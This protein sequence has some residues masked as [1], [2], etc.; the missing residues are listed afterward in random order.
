MSKS[1]F[2]Y[3][4]NG[5]RAYAVM[6]VTLFHFGISG[7]SAGFIGVD[8]FFVI[9]GFLMTSI[10]I[11]GLEKGNFSLLNFYLSRAIR[12]IPALFFLCSILLIIGWFLLLPLDYRALAK[13]SL[14][15]VNFFSNIVYWKESGYFDTESHN[16]ALLHT[17]SLSVEWQFY[18]IFPIIVALL[19]KIKSSRSF[20]FLSFVTTSILSFIL[21]IIITNSNASS[22]F[23]LLPTRA[24]EMLLGGVIFF[25]PKDKIPYQKPMEILGFVLILISCLIFS[26]STLWPSFNAFLPVLG[27]FLILL[28][29]QQNSILTRGKVFQWLGDKSYSIYLWHWP[30]V[31]FLHYYYN[32]DSSTFISLGLA[33]SIFFGW[34]SY[35]F[36]EAPAR[37]YLSSLNKLKAYIIWII[38]VGLITSICLFIFK[39]NGI[40][41]RFSDDIN[42][43]SAI[44]KD[45]NPRVE[46]CL[47]KSNDEKLTKCIYGDGETSLIVIGDSHAD[48]LLNGVLNALPSNKS[49]ITYNISGCS[50]IIG[51]KRTDDK[52]FKCGEKVSKLIKILN[53]YPKNIP[54]LIVNRA[55]VIFNWEL[56]GKPIYYVNS[57]YND[58]SLKNIDEMSEAYLSTIK[59]I[60]QYHKV[61]MTS[62]I[63]ETDVDI[64]SISAKIMAYDLPLQQK[65]TISLA[66]HEELNK[67]VL[68]VQKKASDLYGVKIINLSEFFCDKEFC[69]FTHSNKPLFHDNNHISW[70]A[71]SLLA[72]IFKKEIF[73]R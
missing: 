36:I 44:K 5:L 33:L 54:I 29:N 27:I 35:N 73:E 28:S 16:K 62:P 31:F 48:G 25:I 67:E 8:I 40:T 46:E 52:S 45:K 43:I 20:I 34:L 69:N 19:Y 63:P 3:D 1:N 59:L 17:W 13:H 18:I 68:Y 60:T 7:F 72:P 24:W 50:T 22:G 15:S 51:L 53:K 21:S 47:S 30:I 39:F 56:N 12:I 9:S 10:V 42:A 57:P 11:K 32:H 4:I 66:E 14:S 71:A 41:K 23:F 6:L 58:F 38:S 65:L 2:R 37:K 70:Q 64:P 55:N 49:L 61:Y 26:T